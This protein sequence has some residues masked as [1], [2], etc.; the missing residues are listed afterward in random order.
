M[1]DEKQ[2]IK[3]KKIIIVED[4]NVVSRAFSDILIQENF[5]VDIANDGI[6][7]S[8]K[9][10]SDKPDLV[11][12]DLILPEKNGFEILEEMHKDEALKN[13]PVI[14]L[15]KLGE[16]SKMQ[17]GKELGA[18]DYLIKTDVYLKDVISKIRFYLDKSNS[19]N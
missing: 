3:G 11:L 5:R 10:K 4:D 16:E 8:E 9:I 14:I 7:A 15:T 12:L 18:V 6:E 13:I 17:R 19:K 1:S 2:N